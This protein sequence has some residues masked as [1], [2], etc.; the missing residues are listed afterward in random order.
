MQDVLHQIS[1]CMKTH[2]VIGDAVSGIPS[3]FVLRTVHIDITCKIDENKPR[4]N[5]LAPEE[6]QMRKAVA[7]LIE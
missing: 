5:L 1:V 7:E 6:V 3:S 4:L 2:D